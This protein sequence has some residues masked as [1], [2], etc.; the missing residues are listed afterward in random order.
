MMAK[1]ADLR[2]GNKLLLAFALLILGFGAMLVFSLER[3]VRLQQA[4]AEDF[5]RRYE[6][7]AETKDLLINIL[8]QRI[9]LQSALDGDEGDYLMEIQRSSERSA[10]LLARLRST[11][12]G[13]PEVAMLVDKLEEQRSVFAHTRDTQVLPLIRSGNREEAR[14]LFGGIQNERVDTIAVLGEQLTELTALG[15]RQGLEQAQQALAVQRLQQLQLGLLLAGLAGVFAWWLSRHIAQ[16]LMRLTGWAERIS[17]GDIP[18]DMSSSSRQDEVGR[19]SQA[20]T[21]MGLYL[22]ELA[23]KAERLAQGQLHEDIQAVSERDVL[24]RAFATM[25]RNLRELVQEMNEGITVLAGSSEEILAATSQVASSTQETATAIS[26]IATT[27][28]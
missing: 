2:I 20:F 13:D 21:R 16:P 6:R 11:L 7:V 28:E 12:S 10:R 25:V 24:G 3:F 9:A 22:Q 23:G 18:T 26:E 19:L 17:G 4:D 8:G 14:R 15:V 5:T 1:L 27:V